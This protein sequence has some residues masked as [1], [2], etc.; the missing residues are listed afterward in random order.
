MF[1]PR[2]QVEDS[3]ELI[4][5][6][7]YLIGFRPEESL[8]VMVFDDRRLGVVVRHDLGDT[9]ATDDARIHALIA[10]CRAPAVLLVGV[11]SDP[12]LVHDALAG[13]EQC[14]GPELLIDSLVSDGQHWWSRVHGNRC[15]AGEPIPLSPAG[16]ATAIAAGCAH[17]SSRGELASTVAGPSAENVPRLDD[18]FASRQD[19]WARVGIEDRMQVIRELVM[20][21]VG[22]GR[23]GHE[24]DLIDLA[25]L[26][27]DVAV[28][29]QAWMLLDRESAREHVRLWTEVIA[30]SPPDF[31]TPVLCLLGMAAWLSGNGALQSCCVARGVTLDPQY[32]MLHLLQD[33]TMRAVP[34]DLWDDMEF[35]RSRAAS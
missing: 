15:G 28:R 8:V 19:D 29:D 2:I 5:L 17:L 32:S 7:P 33:L 10:Q 12:Q 27:Q 25:V 11:G 35:R 1:K 16:V 18:E 22:S 23:A 31:A 26:A 4:A 14:F 21:A 9:R 3:G 20:S 6:L 13:A 34:P 30:I 24:S